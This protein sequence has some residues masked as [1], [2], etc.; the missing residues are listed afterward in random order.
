MFCLYFVFT[1]E[2]EAQERLCGLVIS[3]MATIHQS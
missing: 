2:R 1:Y 3:G